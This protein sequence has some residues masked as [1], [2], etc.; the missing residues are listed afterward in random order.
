MKC[1]EIQLAELII[2]ASGWKMSDPKRFFFLHFEPTLF[3]PKA[4]RYFA[5][6]LLKHCK[7]YLTPWILAEQCF[8]FYQGRIFF[9]FPTQPSYKKQVISEQ[10]CGGFF[11]PLTTLHSKST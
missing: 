8:M 4:K 7:I 9:F 2:Q 1:P 5:L 6:H 10:A 11:Q 3:V